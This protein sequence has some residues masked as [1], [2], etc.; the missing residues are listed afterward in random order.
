MKTPTS[1][2]ILFSR[3]SGLTPISS[4]VQYVE[5]PSAPHSTI[6]PKK[7]IQSGSKTRCPYFPQVH[8]SVLD[9][10]FQLVV[11]ERL[12]S[13]FFTPIFHSKLIRSP[14]LLMYTFCD[15]SRSALHL[16][17]QSSCPT[18]SYRVGHSAL[19][20]ESTKGGLHLISSILVVSTKAF[21]FSPGP[22]RSV[23]SRYATLSKWRTPLL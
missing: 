17:T 4:T 20:S 19:Q 15:P 13:T 6:S 11:K 1:M 10:P 23:A 8:P 18:P 22:S 14:T 3:R 5:P 12:A 9:L 21:C 16:T 7:Q 2:S